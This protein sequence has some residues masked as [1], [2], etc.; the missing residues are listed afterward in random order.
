M[1]DLKNINNYRLWAVIV[2]ALVI[3]LFLVYPLVRPL[4]SVY[5]QK[6][7]GTAMLAKAES[8]KRVL[9]ETA[10]AKRDAARLEAEA[11]IERAKGVAE[12]NRIIAGGLENSENYLKY[13][14]ISKISS[15]NAPQ[16]IYIPTETGLP[17]LESGRT[18]TPPNP[19]TEAKND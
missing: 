19:N 17:I 8:E 3:L 5:S 2:V 18:V 6:F 10:K 4:Y 15:S 14:W 1:M 13:L 12:A 16:I 9:V 11:E 7:A